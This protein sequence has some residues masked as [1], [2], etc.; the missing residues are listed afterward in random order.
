MRRKFNILTAASVAGC[1]L[2]LIVSLAT[3]NLEIRKA[4][5]TITQDFHVAFYRGGM[6]FYSASLPYMGSTWMVSETEPKVI[7]NGW[8]IRE[9]GFVREVYTHKTGEIQKRNACDLPGIYYRHFEDSPALPPD[10]IN[11]TL[12]ISFWYP[13]LVFAILPGVWFFERRKQLTKKFQLKN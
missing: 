1:V 8:N 9:Y 7:S 12:M 10:S 3:S 2:V 5:I 13:F 4:G 11:S 6:W